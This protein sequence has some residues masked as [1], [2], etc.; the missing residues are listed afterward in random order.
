MKRIAF[1]LAAAALAGGCQE[2]TQP[3]SLRLEKSDAAVVRVAAPTGNPAVD[4]PNIKAAVDAAT[5]GALIQ[6]ARGTYAIEEATQIAVSVPGVTLQG[7]RRGTTIRGVSSFTLPPSKGHFLLNGG[8]QTVRRLTFEGFAFALSFG[9][10]GT[11]IGGYRVED[12]TF[13]NGHIPIEFI[14]FS[15]DVSTVQGNEFINVTLAF[16]ILGKTVHFRRNRIT[17]PDPAATPFGQPVAAGVLFPEFF[18]GGT[19]CENNV[20]EGNTIVGNADG[21]LLITGP[22]ELCRNNVIRENTFIRQRI[23]TPFDNG[24]MV[25]L[26]GPGVEGNLI[27]ENVLRGSEGLGIVVEAGSRNRIVG[28]AFSDLPGQK[29]TFTPFPGTAI[30]LGEP[31]SGNRVRENEFENVV[32]A[33]VDLGTGNHIGKGQDVADLAAVSALRLSVTGEPSGGSDHPKLRFLRSYGRN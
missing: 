23:F 9:A 19:I 3:P 13:R 31:T 10:P 30:F 14:A 6:F 12:C 24:T 21:F 20:F 1:L 22:G 2:P 5:P 18:S 15:D 4:V 26:I 27:E 29:V 25:F 33:I 28:N 11:A 16:A 7:H 8:H 17:A 32:N